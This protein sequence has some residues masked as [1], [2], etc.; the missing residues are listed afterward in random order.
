LYLEIDAKYRKT[1]DCYVE[2]KCF[3]ETMECFVHLYKMLSI[4]FSAASKIQFMSFYT[5]CLLK[6]CLKELYVNSRGVRKTVWRVGNSFEKTEPNR[7]VQN[8][9]F[10]PDG[11]PNLNAMF[12]S[13]DGGNLVL[14]K[15]YM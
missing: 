2:G 7:T 5:E 13:K 4:C 9:E 15:A 14:V 6:Q 8:F 11:F 3:N 1:A 10:R 12:R